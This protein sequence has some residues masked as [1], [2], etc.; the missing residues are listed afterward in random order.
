MIAL[1][2]GYTESPKTLAGV[3]EFIK[4][5]KL[6]DD[7]YFSMSFDYKNNRQ[8]EG[9]EPLYAEDTRW[10]GVFCV[11]GGSEGYY[12]HVE[13][14]SGEHEMDNIFLGKFWSAK[15]AMEAVTLLTAC[16]NGWKFETQFAF[17]G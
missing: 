3:M 2:H 4:A 11:E 1:T 13:R 14:I 15:R 6:A 10:I 9:D 8:H 5:Q 12:V 7:E 17:A 16:V